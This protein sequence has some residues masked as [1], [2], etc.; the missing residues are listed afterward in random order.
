MPGIN[1]M[2]AT[3]ERSLTLSG[4]PNYITSWYAA[5]NG[6]YFRSAPWCD[7][8]ITYWAYHSGNYSAV[9]FDQDFAYTVY[10]AQRFQ[11][12][13]RW[14]VDVAGIR[15]GDILFFD[16]NFSNGIPYIDH[17]GVVTAVNGADV[18]TI[19]GN[20]SD[21]CA[22][23]VRRADVIA[24]YGRPNYLVPA[25][26]PAPTPSAGN[27]FAG[28]PELKLGAKDGYPTGRFPDRGAPVQTLQNA[29]NI[30]LGWEGTNP[31]KIK[32]DGVFG[33]ATR[34][35]VGVYQRSVFGVGSGVVGP[36]TWLRLDRDLDAKGR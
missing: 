9:C 10:H 11:R 27:R 18:H 28:Y 17:V 16:W 14:V 33:L 1:D 13:G 8:A 7:M 29:L 34:H 36:M 32:A 23:R 21:T 24:G 20:T 31:N 19:E 6:A 5:R 4:R 22:R 15:R 12:D 3:A 2:V 35:V 25:P 30:A 26:I